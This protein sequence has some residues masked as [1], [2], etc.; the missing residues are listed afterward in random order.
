VHL[1]HD[2][3]GGVDDGHGVLL[4]RILGK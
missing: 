4:G 3:L 1:V 2:G